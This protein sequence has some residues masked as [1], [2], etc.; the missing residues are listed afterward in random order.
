MP[1]WRTIYY[2]ENKCYDLTQQ[3]SKRCRV[4]E[5]ISLGW[6]SKDPKKET[7]NIGLLSF[8]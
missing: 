1:P 6:S 5:Q 4:S 7:F 8:V 3:Q 2:K